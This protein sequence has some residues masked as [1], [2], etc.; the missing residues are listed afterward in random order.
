MQ[1]IQYVDSND[2]PLH[3]ILTLQ[4]SVSMKAPVWRLQYSVSALTL[5]WL[6]RLCGGGL[7]VMG[8]VALLEVGIV[9]AGPG[10]GSDR[11]LGSCFTRMAVKSWLNAHM[12]SVPGKTHALLISIRATKDRRATMKTCPENLHWQNG[13][14][15]NLLKSYEWKSIMWY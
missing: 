7:R 8:W 4:S 2:A 6:W 15:N 12:P 5:S 1:T 11:R 14:I 10:D 9:G 3:N 13:A